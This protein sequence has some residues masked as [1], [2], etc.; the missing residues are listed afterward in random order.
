MAP[1]PTR[2]HVPLG[3]RAYD[4]EIGRGLIDRDRMF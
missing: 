2:V 4:I 3:E 1:E